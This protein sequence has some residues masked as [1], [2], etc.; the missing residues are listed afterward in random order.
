MHFVLAGFGHSEH[1]RRYYFDAVE[2]D[3]D[4]K[5]VTVSADVDVARKCGIALQELPLLCRR[6]LDEHPDAAS[7]HF[8]EPEMALCVGR[9]S[10]ARIVSMVCL[11][12]LRLAS[13]YQVR[14]H[15]FR[16]A[17]LA[18]EDLHG[19][20]YLKAYGVSEQFRLNVVRARTALRDHREAH[21][22]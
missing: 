8:T 12:R 9:R 13:D 2:K 1:T 18:L 7:I 6:L 4:R 19:S 3:Q 5:R 14:V 20:D 11:E 10:V 15:A 16:D 17:V 22:C 21:R